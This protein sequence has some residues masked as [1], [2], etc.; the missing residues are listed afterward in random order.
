MYVRLI[1]RHL[2]KLG[3]LIQCDVDYLMGGMKQA[4]SNSAN[5]YLAT[6]AFCS[7]GLDLP[8]LDTIIFA[9]PRSSIT[10][11]MGRIMRSPDASPLV[12]DLVDKYSLFIGEFYRRRRIYT[13]AGL[14]L[15]HTP[16]DRLVHVLTDTNSLEHCT[17]EP[18]DNEPTDHVV[19]S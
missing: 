3:T 12:I 16:A 7:E 15:V 4:P 14:T 17:D 2:K 9:T 8:K 1:K 10:Q 19:F 18:M 5:L 11:S 6:Y 13:K